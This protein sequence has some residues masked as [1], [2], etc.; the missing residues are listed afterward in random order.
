LDLH[1]RLRGLQFGA[2][3]EPDAQHS[4]GVVRPGRSVSE[5]R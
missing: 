2:H 3:A 1:V 4:F 5:R